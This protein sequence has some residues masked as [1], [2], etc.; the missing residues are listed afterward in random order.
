MLPSIVPGET[1]WCFFGHQIN[2]KQA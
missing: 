2:W 1:S